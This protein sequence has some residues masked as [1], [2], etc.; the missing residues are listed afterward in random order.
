MHSQP[1]E[2]VIV[3][4]TVQL[5]VY[6]N[7]GVKSW[8]VQQRVVAVFPCNSTALHTYTFVAKIFLIT[9]AE[10]ALRTGHEVMEKSDTN[11]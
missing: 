10:G 4:P 2:S 7:R 5:V 11:I 9:R 6:G 3:V 1:A 8:A